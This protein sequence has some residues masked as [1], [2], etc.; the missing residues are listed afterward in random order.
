MATSME[1]YEYGHHLNIGYEAWA[2][3]A[4]FAGTVQRMFSV[5]EQNIYR[6][7]RE[8]IGFLLNLFQL[9]K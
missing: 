8:Y 7:H 5:Q 1:E 4:G 9:L 6:T 3:A 2:V